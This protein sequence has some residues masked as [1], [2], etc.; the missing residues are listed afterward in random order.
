MKSD[1]FK[2]LVFVCGLLSYSDTEVRMKSL[3]ILEDD[4]NQTI[5]KLDTSDL[6]LIN[7]KYYKKL[8]QDDNKCPK[9]PCW[10]CDAM[11]YAGF[12]TFLNHKC[13]Q[14]NIVDHKKGYCKSTGR[15]NSSQNS[16]PCKKKNKKYKNTVVPLQNLM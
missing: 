6:R 11:H 7:L 10:N 2:C 14:C 8:K 5:N 3:A 12:Y 1:Q 15:A 9:T 16:F 13:S 4:S